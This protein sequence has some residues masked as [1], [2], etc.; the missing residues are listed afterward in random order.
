MKILVFTAVFGETDKQKPFAAQDV[1]EPWLCD[2]VFITEN[3]SPVPLPNLPP[4]LQ[5]KYFKTQAHHIWPDY[6]CY[7]W[8]DGNVEVTSKDFVSKLM[9]F[10]GSTDIHIQSHHERTTIG[11]EVSFILGSN[12]PYLLVRYL[13]QPLQQEY[14]YY[15]GQGM[16]SN[17]AL[18]SC[19]IF[20]YANTPKACTFM[21]AWWRL[22][23]EWSWFDQSAFSYLADRMPWVVCTVELGGVLSSPYH[24]LHG[25][26]EWNK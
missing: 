10:D 8:I 17:A 26:D 3:N 11:Q 24:I 25:H 16:S 4:R 21:D 23:I 1:T 14:N 12:N 5:A 7:I 18:Y 20:A 13:D 9:G 19:N 2:R 6:D 22:C 15:I